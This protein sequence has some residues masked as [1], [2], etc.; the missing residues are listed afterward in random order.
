MNETAA[1]ATN[2]FAPIWRR[3]W[4]ILA[5]ALLVAVGSYLYFKRQHPTF[6][7]QT[8]VFMGASAEEQALAGRATRRRATR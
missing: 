6:Q 7:N 5:V 8:Q 1:D 2:I 4:L 3:K